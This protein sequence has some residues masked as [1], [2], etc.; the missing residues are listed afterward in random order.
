MFS[1]KT[2]LSCDICG[3]TKSSEGAR[4]SDCFSRQ[5]HR[6]LAKEKGWRVFYGKY[7]VCGYCIKLYDE[8]Y[9]REVLKEREKNG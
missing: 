2:Q 4:M 7:E 1:C 6:M 5:W 8:K 3:R 9:I